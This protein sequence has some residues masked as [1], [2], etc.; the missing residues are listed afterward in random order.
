M[1]AS[2]GPT[3]RDAQAQHVD[4]VVLDGLARRVAVVADGGADAGELAGRDRDAG[5]AAA[6][7]DAAVDLAVAD[8]GGHRLGDVGVVDRRARMRA[9]IQDFV[10]LL[11]HDAR[12][13]RASVRT[14]HGRPR[15]QRA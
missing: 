10:A 11:G 5:A 13:G 8:G 3:T 14:R 1:R 4:V 15:R 2:A 7:D 9:Q 6:D 12:P